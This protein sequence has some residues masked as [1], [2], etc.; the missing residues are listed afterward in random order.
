MWTSW[1]GSWR[2]KWHAPCE[3]YLGGEERRDGTGAIKL[4]ATK[5]EKFKLAYADHLP[6]RRERT[7]ARVTEGFSAKPQMGAA[8][9]AERAQMVGKP[10]R[11]IGSAAYPARLAH[12]SMAYVLSEVSQQVADPSLRVWKMMQV[13]GDF[14]GAQAHEGLY[15]KAMSPGVR[16]L[17]VITDANHWRCKVTRR[18]V[19]AIAVFLWGNLVAYGAKKQGHVSFFF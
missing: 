2:S 1:W 6:G 8:D 3:E 18:S 13:A 12:P 4:T 17:A 5:I 14:L 15:F 10:L 11:P 7:P 9:D 16:Q 19:A